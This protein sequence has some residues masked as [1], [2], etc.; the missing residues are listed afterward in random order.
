MKSDL[1]RFGVV[2]L[3]VLTGKRAILEEAQGASP[4][5]VVDYA[6]PSIISRELGKVLDP[7]VPKPSAR[8]AE[9]L[10]LVAYIALHLM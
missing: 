2:M 6:I 5:S 1:Y 4:L 10:G 9:A 7:R 8:E 3:E